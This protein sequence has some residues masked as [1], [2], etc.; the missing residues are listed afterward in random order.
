MHDRQDGL[1]PR[2]LRGKFPKSW[3]LMLQKSTRI[4]L[5]INL[6]VLSFLILDATLVGPPHRSEWGYLLA[7]LLGPVAVAIWYIVF[8]MNPYRSLSAIREGM[9]N[10]DEHE[11]DAKEFVA[12]LKSPGARRFLLNTAWKLS[13]LFF[14]P[15]AILSAL[16]HMT[17]IW[18]FGADCVVR[19][20]A[21]LF[22]CLFV[23]FRMEILAWG[24]KSWK[25]S[26]G[27]C[28]ITG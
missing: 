6:L 26:D 28:K 11:H 13:L 5:E 8:P 16:M 10:M 20:P 27:T 2:A 15:M 14:V 24:L 9:K 12:L 22:I 17:P 23:L 1:V 7:A 25:G 19:I 18:R 21:F 4:A 3:G